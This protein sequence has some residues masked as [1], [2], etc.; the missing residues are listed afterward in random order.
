MPVYSIYDIQVYGQYTC[1]TIQYL[2]HLTTEFS[3]NMPVN[4]IYD[5]QVYTFN[6]DAIQT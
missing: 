6:I 3:L 1:N 5:I 2:D 4:S